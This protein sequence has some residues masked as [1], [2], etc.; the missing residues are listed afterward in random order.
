MIV[1]PPRNPFPAQATAIIEGSPLGE[2]SQTTLARPSLERLRELIARYRASY[3]P[4]DDGRVIA[5]HGQHGSGKTHALGDAMV[6]L[7]KAGDAPVRTIYV[8]ADSPDVLSLYRKLMSQVSMQDLQELCR[9]A[10]QQYAREELADSR[11]LGPETVSAALETAE[12]AGGDWVTRAFR[13]AELQAT[14]VLDRQ[15]SDLAREGMRQKDFERVVPSLLNH[16]LDEIAYR[17]LRAERL[18]DSELRAL[19]ISENIDDPLRIRTGI[20]TLLILSCR[21]GRPLAIL[22]DQA[23]AFVTTDAM[24]LDLD[25]VGLLKAVLESVVTNSGLLIAAVRESAWQ[26]LPPDLRQRF[27]PSEI[28]TAGL[29]E[30]EAS[31][32]VA[33]F[34]SPWAMPPSADEP[35]TFPFLPDGLMET[36]VS[37]GGN[38]R[39]F[40][41]LCS[42]LF[43]VAAPRE[44]AVDREFARNALSGQA[45]RVPDRETLRRQLTDLLIWAHVQYLADFALGGGAECDF[46]VTDPAGGFRAFIVVTDALLAGELTVASRTLELVRRAQMLPQPA[47]VVLVVGGYLSPELTTQLNKVQRVIVVT[48]EPGQHDLE[49]LVSDLRTAAFRSATAAETALRQQLDSVLAALTAVQD[50]RKRE[51]QSLSE[52]LDALAQAQFDQR[53]TDE[54]GETARQWRVTEESLREKIQTARAERRR[55]ELDE[56]ERLRAAAE[57]GW[58]LTVGSPGLLVF[59]AAAV[60]AG[61]GLSRAGGERLIYWPLAG[62]FAVLALMLPSL[63]IWLHARHEGDLGK[64]VSSFQELDRL[65]RGFQQRVVTYSDAS[66]PAVSQVPAAIVTPP[67]MPPLDSGNPQLTYAASLSEFRFAENELTQALGK[68]RSAFARRSLVTKLAGD[69]QMNGLK[70]VVDTIGTDP[71]TSAAFDSLTT[72]PGG[73]P[74]PYGLPP[75][76]S[77]PAAPPYSLPPDSAAL[78]V[79]ESTRSPSAGALMDDKV[80]ARLTPELRAVAWIYGFV[81]FGRESSLLADFIQPGDY[82]FGAFRSDDERENAYA[83]AKRARELR[84]CYETGDNGQLQRVLRTLTEREIRAAAAILSPLDAG[85]AGTF[86]W[87]GKTAEIE[88]VYLFFQKCI[89]YLGRG[90]T[91]AAIEI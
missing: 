17:W 66:A 50:D 88:E 77:A 1:Y 63:F 8:R 39:R 13:Q 49:L 56:L 89:F 16:D 30:H 22:I 24:T 82:D 26:L 87:L 72:R 65:A 61:L 27:G 43:T 7:S 62:G 34:V 44:L 32:L 91:A 3:D 4:A 21:A 67:W 55:A 42:L 46:A 48:S 45:A 20:Q 18:A 76:T 73:T 68:Q 74:A 54:A 10:R 52:Q 12:G 28:Q 53:V 75:V 90:I 70:M 51:Q 38:I 80:A 60:L 37:S 29:T 79:L 31:D 83:L 33:L 11:D 19:G 35:S 81:Y 5:V 85:K 84:L 57:R 58:R 64:P 41:Q 86:D 78:P 47:E 23:E 71:A 59:A 6:T 9:L 40:I 14:A 36:L 2:L 69:Y 15:I 25:N